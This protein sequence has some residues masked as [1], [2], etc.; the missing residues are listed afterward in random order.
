M[1]ISASAAAPV[2]RSRRAQ[3]SPGLLR[4]PT[5]SG[6]VARSGRPGSSR[7]RRSASP[8]LLEQHVDLG[9]GQRVHDTAARQP[10]DRHAQLGGHEVLRVRAVLAEVPDPLRRIR[11]QGGQ[12]GAVIAFC[13]NS[14]ASPAGIRPASSPRWRASW[15]AR[16]ACS[17]AQPIGS[18]SPW[19]RR[20]CA[21]SPSGTYPVGRPR[22]GPGSGQ[23][24]PEAPLELRAVVAAE[25][26]PPRCG[27]ARSTW[28]CS[29]AGRYVRT[30]H[31]RALRGDH[32]GRGAHRRSLLGAA[33]RDHRRGPRWRADPGAAR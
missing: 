16:W 32:G 28:P 11:L 8:L 31:H 14:G 18:L 26:T 10:G 1:S 25:A 24:H 29:A 3:L 33:D 13:W 30:G 23:R 15:T 9:G 21:R 19:L 2:T 27:P 12:F 22:S 17:S 7:V 6:G 5:P 20:R 4:T